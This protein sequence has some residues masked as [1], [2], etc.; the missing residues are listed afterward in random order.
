MKAE[1]SKIV[2]DVDKKKIEL[3][4]EQAKKMKEVLDELFGV[5]V[6]HHHHD[7]HPYRSYPYWHWDK[8]IIWCGSNTQLTFDS[9]TVSCSL[10]SVSKS[11]AR[12][13]EVQSSE[14]KQA[15]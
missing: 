15:R 12:R 14:E 7:H 11:Q 2:I 6:E 8:D 10:D 13:L 9:G 1:I 4:K 3:T 5:T